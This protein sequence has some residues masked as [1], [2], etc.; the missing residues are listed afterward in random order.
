MRAAPNRLSVSRK[1]KSLVRLVRLFRYTLCVPGAVCPPGPVPLPG[2]AVVSAGQEGQGRRVLV[3][4]SHRAAV[5]QAGQRRAGVVPVAYEAAQ[6][7]ESAAAGEV[8]QRGG[9]QPQPETHHMTCFYVN[10][11][12]VCQLSVLGCQNQ[13]RVNRTLP[14]NPSLRAEC[15][16]VEILIYSSFSAK[17]KPLKASKNIWGLVQNGGTSSGSDNILCDLQIKTNWFG[18]FILQQKTF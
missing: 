17:K 1:W 5:Q 3:G 8:D 4:P 14:S 12:E 9:G 10:V 11:L 18:C 2:L 15:S 13:L 16:R 6:P 7:A